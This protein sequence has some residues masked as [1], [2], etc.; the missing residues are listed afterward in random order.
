VLKKGN[1]GNVMRVAIVLLAI[2]LQFIIVGCQGADRDIVFPE[3]VE[4]SPSDG[5]IL[6]AFFPVRAVF[7]KPMDTETVEITVGDLLGDITFNETH[8]EFVWNLHRW[9]LLLPGAPQ[10]VAVT[11]RDKEGNVLVGYKPINVNVAFGE[12]EP[13]LITRIVPNV[14]QRLAVDLQKV[15]VF[16]DQD[17]DPAST[18]AVT[19]EGGGSTRL[20]VLWSG[21]RAE[22]TFQQQLVAKT[23]YTV[24][25]NL[26][27]WG[28]FPTSTAFTF[29]TIGD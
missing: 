13:I 1:F 6:P 18:I 16:F 9:A 19:S 4:I 11:G 2:S 14:E 21:S 17:V 3:V 27:S 5:E 28:W 8:T 7:N 22:I 23:T 24:V 10:P 20:D 26:L 25:L 29:T 12:I 15:I